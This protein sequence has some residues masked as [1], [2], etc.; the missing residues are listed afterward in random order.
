MDSVGLVEISLGA[1][2]KETLQHFE[3]R[4]TIHCERSFGLLNFMFSRYEMSIF[5]ENR[6]HLKDVVSSVL[7]AGDE[8]ALVSIVNGA[9]VVFN[10]NIFQNIF[11]FVLSAI[12][13]NMPSDL[14][15]AS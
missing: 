2:I 5:F 13:S 12:F 3:V 6:Q 11:E 9:D 10:S 1:N 8:S 7:N 14:S 15:Q 4:R